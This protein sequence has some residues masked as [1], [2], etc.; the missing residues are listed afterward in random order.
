MQTDIDSLKHE[1]E[2]YSQVINDIK[3][4]KVNEKKVPN[5]YKLMI[6]SIDEKELANKE[7]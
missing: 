1:L 5:A 7:E 6:N 3:D 2:H 4:N